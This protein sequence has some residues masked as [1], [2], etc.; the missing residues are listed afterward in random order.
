ME[1]SACT[2]CVI[3]IFNYVFVFIT[4][5]YFYNVLNF[6]LSKINHSTVTSN[7][8]TLN[9]NHSITRGHNLKIIKERCRL[10]I[11]KK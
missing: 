6:I 3:F 7:I 8:V 9:E 11:H 2:A 4:Y 10:N 5:I 1:I